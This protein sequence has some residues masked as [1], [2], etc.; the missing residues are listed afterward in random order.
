MLHLKHLSLIVNI[1]TFVIYNMICIYWNDWLTDWL[2]DTALNFILYARQI[3]YL[4]N[5]Q[6]RILTS[7]RSVIIVLFGITEFKILIWILF[8]KLWYG[9][10]FLKIQYLR[11]TI[12]SMHSSHFLLYIRFDFDCKCFLLYKYA[13]KLF[14]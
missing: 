11:Y 14:I 5:K 13:K 3:L 2:T 7:W 10:Q 4:Q 6:S 12:M 9:N 8:F 1:V